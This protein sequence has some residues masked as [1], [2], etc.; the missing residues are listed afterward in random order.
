VIDVA[1][2]APYR[3]V[4]EALVDVPELKQYGEFWRRLLNAAAR[5]LAQGKPQQEADLRE[6]LRALLQFLDSGM[7]QEQSDQIRAMLLGP[8]CCRVPYDSL[9]GNPDDPTTPLGLFCLMTPHDEGAEGGFPVHLPYTLTL[10]ETWLQGPGV[11]V[12][13]IL[14]L[15]PDTRSET[16]RQAASSV[17]NGGRE[18]GASRVTFLSQLSARATDELF[19]RIPFLAFTSARDFYQLGSRFYAQGELDYFKCGVTSGCVIPEDYYGTEVYEAH[20]PGITRAETLRPGSFRNDAIASHDTWH[21]LVLAAVLGPDGESANPLNPHRPIYFD[22]ALK[23][24]EERG[25]HFHNLIDIEQTG[26]RLRARAEH[27]RRRQ[28]S[29]EYLSDAVNVLA[30]FLSHGTYSAYFARSLDSAWRAELPEDDATSASFLRAPVAAPY[31][32]SLLS[33]RVSVY[34]TRGSLRAINR[35]FW[36][37]PSVLEYLETPSRRGWEIIPFYLLGLDKQTLDGLL[38]QQGERRGYWLA[39]LVHNPV[40]ALFSKTCRVDIPPGRPPQEVRAMAEQI[41]AELL[42]PDMATI[43]R[44]TGRPFLTLSDLTGVFDRSYGR[45]RH[46]ISEYNLGAYSVQAHDHRFTREGLRAFVQR[47]LVGRKGFGDAVMAEVE[48]RIDRAFSTP[49]GRT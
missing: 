27:W 38:E 36:V 47:E 14:A 37:N 23:H 9:P 18:L 26:E 5:Q 48:A 2:L 17:T 22:T 8:P 30:Y 6:V 11:A 20:G 41:V 12:P 1:N 42:R 46:W 49:R 33:D 7:P 31:L 16:L 43:L 3:P 29:E 24:V 45:L 15:H 39:R 34:T 19:M 21:K 10:L 4:V 13:T 44:P 35:G 25:G 40:K 32:V 28:Q